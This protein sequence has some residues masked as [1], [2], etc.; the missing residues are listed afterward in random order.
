MAVSER[1]LLDRW[2]LWPAAQEGAREDA[3]QVAPE[4]TRRDGDLAPLVVMTTENGS[5]PRDAKFGSKKKK[6]PPELLPNGT[7]ILSWEKDRMCTR[8][9]SGSSLGSAPSTQVF[10]SA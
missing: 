6:S 5:A 2:L 9:G 10:I 7:S 1:E 4:R 3:R 8:P